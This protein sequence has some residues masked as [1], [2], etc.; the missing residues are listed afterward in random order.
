MKQ[1]EKL[2]LRKFEEKK[3]QQ[4]CKHYIWPNLYHLFKKRTETTKISSK[5]I[6]NDPLKKAIK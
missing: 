1:T 3:K 6:N 2:I 5:W 4:H